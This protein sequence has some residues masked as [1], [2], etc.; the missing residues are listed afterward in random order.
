MIG[1]P[2]TLAPKM[3][4]ARKEGFVAGIPHR[5]ARV[6]SDARKFLSYSGE[7]AVMPAFVTVSH[8]G[9]ATNVLSDPMVGGIFAS[10]DAGPGRTAYLA[11]GIPR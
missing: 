11:G 10:K 8:S 7:V 3:P 4:L 9:R 5:F 1:G 2:G 6:I